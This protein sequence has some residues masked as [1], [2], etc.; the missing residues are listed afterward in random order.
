M[1]KQRLKIRFFVATLFLFTLLL[2]SGCTLESGLNVFDSA[3]ETSLATVEEDQEVV[4]LAE[5]MEHTQSDLVDK[6]WFRAH[7][8]NN[9]EKR[10][11]TYMTVNGI[12]VR[13]HGYYMHN[14]LVAQPFEYYRWDDNIYVRQNQNWFRGREA[15]LPFDIFYGFEHW[16]PYLERATL[17]GEDEVLS[18]PTF[19]YEIELTGEEML[20]MDVPMFADLKEDTEKIKP[21]L[22]E[23]KVRVLFYVGQADKSTEQREVLPIIY[24]YQTWIQM[25]IP[26]AG[27]MEQ[28]VQHFIFRVNEDNVE[29]NSLE[30]IEKYVIEI[31][32]VLEMMEEELEKELKQNQ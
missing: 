30:E 27:Y 19:V 25:P 9:I 11:T 20:N 24:K 8:A 14:R 6:F 2:L 3:V 7:V 4:S 31:D 28:E 21:L 32:E 23:T 12:V 13:P 18:V 1:L 10:R 29:M 15:S 26:G 17:L 22:N 5:A 16:Q